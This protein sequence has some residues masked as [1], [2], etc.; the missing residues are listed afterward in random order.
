MK[1]GIA[2]AIVGLAFAVLIAPLAVRAQPAQRTVR[3]GY[4]GNSS[5]KLESNLTEALREGLRGRLKV[6]VL[7]TGGTPGTLAAKRASSTIPII[8]VGVGDPLGAGLVSS[9][10]KPGGNVTGLATLARDLEGKRL[11]LLKEAA[12]GVSRVAVLKNPVNPF[13]ALAW[14]GMQPA[15]ETLG[16]KLDP[17]EV[18]T[19]DEFEQAFKAIKNHHGEALILIADRFLLAHRSQ[20][21]KLAVTNHLPGV[22][23]F[24][25]FAKEGGLIAYAPNY[26][27]M[28]RRAATF[29]D[30]IVRG[31]KPGE[32]PVEQPSKFELVINL[33]T[34]KALGLTIPASL[35]L[36]AD[37]LI[38]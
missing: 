22:F 30:R 31:A 4:L 36:R 2:A 1:L 7:V 24:S 21:V 8:M 38:E 28:Y 29:I 20:I 3:I 6:D 35:L 26:P 9:L 37:Q 27:D 5:A 33:K 19:A 17:I 13:T 25:E 16:L 18:R 11:E 23:P 32:L 12:P 34:A 15:A 14:K 10:A